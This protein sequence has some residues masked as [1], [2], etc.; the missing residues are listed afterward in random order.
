MNN[1]AMMNR[2]KQLVVEGDSLTFSWLIRAQAAEASGMVEFSVCMRQYN[3]RDLLAEFNST[4]ASM[5][6]LKSIHK[7]DAEND[8]NYSGIFAVLDQAALDRAVIA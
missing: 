3:G 8:S 1:E 5:K 4:T 7:E 2:A 6:C